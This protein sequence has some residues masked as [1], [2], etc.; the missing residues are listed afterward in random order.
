M[1]I[2]LLNTAVTAVI[3]IFCLNTSI[4]VSAEQLTVADY[5]TLE[6]E[7]RRITLM[8]VRQRLAL[9][10]SNATFDIQMQEDNAIQQQ[11]DNIY[12]QYGITIPSAL[13]WASQHRQAIDNYLTNHPDQQ[14]EYDR[15]ADELDAVSKQIQ[16]L[17]QR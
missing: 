5:V 7:A 14:D 17:L 15:I 8:G 1:H 13:I 2:R 3:L 11:V 4:P 10:Q 9:L 6:L 16:T 12:R